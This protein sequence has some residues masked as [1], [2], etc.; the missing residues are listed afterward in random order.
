MKKITLHI[1]LIIIS[2]TAHGQSSNVVRAIF[3]R[4]SIR[5]GEQFILDLSFEQAIDDSTE[6]IWPEFDNY[7][8]N[9]IE[10]IKKTEVLKHDVD[11]ANIGTFFQQRFIL[12]SFET[13]R[14]GIPAF[15]IES[16]DSIYLTE[17]Y[18]IHVSTVE[19]DTSKGIFDV[20]P[21]FEVDYS[22]SERVSDWLSE[23]WYWI[24]IGI[25]ILVLILLFVRYK[26]QPKIIIEVPKPK[27]PAHITAL[28]ILN[29]LKQGKA[30]ESENKKEYYSSVTDTIRKYLEERFDILALEKTTVEIIKDLKF[31]DII[32]KDKF[33]LQEILKQADLVKFAKFKPDDSDGEIV[34]NK[35]IEFVER[36][37]K[38]MNDT[39]NPKIELNRE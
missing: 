19:V 36:T 1:L 22:V 25:L 24:V 29:D 38:E 33:F 37:K 7:L 31:N 8:T 4:D 12:T 35:S 5:I 39:A 16:S 27:I 2:I 10:I 17:T 14:L 18:S 26:K 28:S 15:Q 34:L 30:W 11:S 13:G 3:N 9:D 23:Y 32:S 20:K 6:V 21:I